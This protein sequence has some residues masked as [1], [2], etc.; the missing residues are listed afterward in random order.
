MCQKAESPILTA[1]VGPN[2]EDDLEG[3]RMMAE[4]EELSEERKGMT[5]PPTSPSVCQQPSTSPCQDASPIVEVSQIQTSN[6]LTPNQPSFLEVQDPA[7][8]VKTQEEDIGNTV[9]ASPAASLELHSVELA[10]DVQERTEKIC[11]S[12]STSVD[13]DITQASSPSSPC[14]EISALGNQYPGSC[15]WSLEL[16]IAAALCATRDAQLAAPVQVPTC[17]A[18]PQ[19]GMALLSELAELERQQQEKNGSN[20]E[21]AGTQINVHISNTVCSHMHIR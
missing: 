20:M 10:E 7:K 11:I 8:E 21:S 12:P 16:L 2:V 9:Q 19:N 3:N 18:P 4:K 15:I 13:L 17:I 6:T 1:Q 5:C 14:S